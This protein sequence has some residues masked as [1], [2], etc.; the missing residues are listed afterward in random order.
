MTFYEARIEVKHDCPYCHITEQFPDAYVSVWCNSRSHV[1]EIASESEEDRAVIKEHFLQNSCDS[2]S[3]RNGRNISIVTRD[4]DCSP[5]NSVSVL[6][7]Q[8]GCWSIPPSSYHGGWE[9]YR[10]MTYKK[11]NIAKL[12]KSIE[13]IGGTVKLASIKPLGEEGMSGESSVTSGHIVAGLTKKQIDALT[14]A[15]QLGYF[16]TPARIDADAMAK[17]VGLSRSTFAEH[18]R[19]AESKVLSNIFPLLE[20]VS[21]D[22]RAK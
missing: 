7:D 18:L 11:E 13:G 15:Y 21:R 19:K 6:I 16:E 20:M 9:F 17:R 22:M 12:I 14:K 10:I 2:D 3:F 5:E 8:S 4:C 1:L